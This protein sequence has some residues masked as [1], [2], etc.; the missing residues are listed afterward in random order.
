[1]IELA[2]LAILAVVVALATKHEKNMRKRIRLN[3]IV[4]KFTMLR[5]DQKGKIICL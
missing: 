2:S 1:M 4:K 5:E 3:R